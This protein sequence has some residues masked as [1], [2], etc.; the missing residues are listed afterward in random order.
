MPYVMGTE[1]VI[2]YSIPDDISLTIFP[3]IMAISF[4]QN[5]KTLGE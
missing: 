5:K 1:L 3:F 4:Q 2:F